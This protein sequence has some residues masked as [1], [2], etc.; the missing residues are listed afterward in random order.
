MDERFH[1]SADRVR[2]SITLGQC[3]PAQFRAV[4][5]NVPFIDR[6]AWVDAVFGLDEL[7]DD[8]P[9][10]PSRCVPYLPC[11]V[12]VLLRVA[13]LVPVGS[14]DVFVDIGAGL[15]RAAVLMH[16]LTGASALGIEVQTGHVNAARALATRLCMTNVKFVAGDAVQAAPEF[17]L[18]S[19]FFLYCPFSGER[20]VKLLEHFEAIARTRPICICAV[21]LPLPSCSWLE[22]VG[23][24]AGDLAIYWS[25]GSEATTDAPFTVFPP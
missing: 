5:M 8:G 25:K 2:L 4:L 11:A 17:A 18:G 1:E 3:D 21:D 10:L 19:V 6:D 24:E 16:L 15:G 12:D 9:E 20:L 14:T 7:L 22:R 13:D 23:P